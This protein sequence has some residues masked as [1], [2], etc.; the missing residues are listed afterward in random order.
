MDG[1]RRI[2]SQLLV[3]AV[4]VMMRWY[5]VTL[6]EIVMRSLALSVTLSKIR[7]YGCGVKEIDAA[8]DV[9][10]SMLR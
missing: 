2:E 6:L 4:I 10:V 9:D 7:C 1:G 5:R 3:P 8:D